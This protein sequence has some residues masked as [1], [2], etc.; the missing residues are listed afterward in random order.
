MVGAQRVDRDPELLAVALERLDLHRDELVLDP[1]GDRACRRSARCG[2][3]WRACGRAGGPCGRRAAGRRRPA[4]SSPRGRGAGR[5]RA[6]R[7]RPRGRPRSC[8]AGSVACGPSSVGR[9]AVTTASRTPRPG[10]GSRSG[11]AG[12]RRRSRCRP[13]AARGARRRRARTT[14]P[15]LDERD[16]A[17]AGLVHRRVAR[18]A[19]AARRA[20][21]RGA[22]SSARWPGSGGVRI[23]KRVAALGRAAAAALGGADD[24]SRCRPRRG[25]AAGD[26]RSSRPAAMRPA[27]GSVGLVSP[28]ST[29]LSIGALTPERSARSRSERSI[30][31]RS[32]LHARADV[33]RRLHLVERPP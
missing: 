19:G 30:A 3:R 29:W 21:G 24:A 27:T 7:A 5:C 14:L 18:A 12:R 20:P 10:R 32:A 6:G 15:R 1:R 13:R 33:D 11:G 4:G 9:P 26:R 22:T 28:R 8:R 31:S 2:R 23:S 17:A 25:A 16:L